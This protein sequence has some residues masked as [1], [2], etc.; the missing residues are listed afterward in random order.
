M[1]KAKG[2]GRRTPLGRSTYDERF[3]VHDGSIR[4]AEKAAE[5][6]KTVGSK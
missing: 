5:G 4:W 6:P 3:P 2:H 1:F